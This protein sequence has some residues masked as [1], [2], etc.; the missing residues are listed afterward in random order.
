M[1]AAHPKLE[2]PVTPDRVIANLI[3][4]YKKS[5]NQE[6]DEHWRKIRRDRQ[7]KAAASGGN[8]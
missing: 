4:L 2:R 6:K 3:R 1:Y 8:P 5:E 7:Q